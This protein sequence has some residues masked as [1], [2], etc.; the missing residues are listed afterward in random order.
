MFG[1]GIRV[2]CGR[3]GRGCGRRGRD[4]GATQCAHHGGRAAI[5]SRAKVGGAA[6]AG[7]RHGRKRTQAAGDVCCSASGD[8]IVTGGEDGTVKVWDAMKGKCLQTLNGYTELEKKSN[9]LESVESKS[10]T[11]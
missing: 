1:A 5:L 3:G 10:S 4:R 7:A 11:K 2:H 8:C 9:K 6:R